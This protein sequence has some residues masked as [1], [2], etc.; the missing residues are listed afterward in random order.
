MTPERLSSSLAA[1][2][3]CVSAC[4]HVA[5]PLCA[6]PYTNRSKCVDKHV[7][8]AWDQ[9]GKGLSCDFDLFIG[10]KKAFEEDRGMAVH[11]RV[12]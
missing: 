1:D 5:C 8:L 3:V 4:M 7:A 11:G 9:Y 10:E 6:L 2:F 12:T